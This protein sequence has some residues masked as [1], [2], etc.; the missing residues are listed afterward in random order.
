MAIERMLGWKDACQG[1]LLP[2]LCHQSVSR[3]RTSGGS[4]VEACTRLQS[5]RDLSIRHGLHWLIKFLGLL[6]VVVL[7]SYLLVLLSVRG[8]A[9]GVIFDFERILRDWFINIAA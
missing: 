7:C 4:T 1:R 8:D 3:I 9:P 6:I 2:D 5:R